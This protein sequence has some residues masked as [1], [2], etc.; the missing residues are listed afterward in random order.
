MF[1]SS[2]GGVRLLRCVHLI[3]KLSKRWLSSTSEGK[4][5]WQTTGQHRWL[6]IPS[7]VLTPRSR[8]STITEQLRRDRAEALGMLK[9]DADVDQRWLAMGTSRVEE[10]FMVINRLC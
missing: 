10:A 9:A 6:D 5:T 2:R 4:I 8:R 7:G 3:S 1:Q